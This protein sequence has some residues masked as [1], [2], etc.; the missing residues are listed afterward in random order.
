MNLLMSLLLLALGATVDV[1]LAPDQPLPY[2][3]IDDPLILEFRAEED[4]LIEAQI[5]VIAAHHPEERLEISLPPIPI[6]AGSSRW[7]AVPDLPAERG[8]YTVVTTTTLNGVSSQSHNEFSRIDRNT[9]R[10]MPML[11]AHNLVHGARAMPALQNAAVGGVRL[12]AGDPE[13]EQ[14]IH[15]AAMQGFDV[16]VHIDSQTLEDPEALVTQLVDRFCLDIARWDITFAEEI[17]ILERIVQTLRSTGC[18]API[19]LTVRDEAHL[20]DLLQQGVGL[21]VRDVVLLHDA[22]DPGS[23]R[24][25]QQTIQAAGYERWRIHV[26]GHGVPGAYVA[27]TEG[28]RSGAGQRLVQ[29]LL[30]NLAAG[31]TS[32]SIDARL[33]YDAGLGE[34]LVYLNALAQHLENARYVGPAIQTATINAPLFRRGNQWFIPL[35]IA[36]AARNIELPVGDVEQLTLTDVLNNPM[37]TPAVQANSGMISLGISNTP[38]FLQG[39]GGNILNVAARNLAQQHAAEVLAL[40]A[41]PSLESPLINAETREIL[42]RIAQRSGSEV[43]RSDFLLLLN[44]FPELEQRWHQGALPQNITVPALAGIAQLARALCVLERQRETPFLEPM[45]DI[46]NRTEEMQSL[47]LTGSTSTNARG[48]QRGDWLLR[49]VR[50]LMDEVEL[51]VQD[52]HKEEATAVANLAAWRARGLE[53]AAQAAP[54]DEAVRLAQAVAAEQPQALQTAEI[55][56]QR[57]SQEDP[58]A[59]P[60]S[61]DAA[62]AEEAD[63]ETEEAESP[64]RIVHEVVSGDTPGGIANRYGVSLADFRRWNN[65]ST[66]A[67]IRIGE[68]Y[69]IL[70]EEEEAE[71]EVEVEEVAEEA[72][73]APE[74]DTT[75]EPGQP[76]GTRKV[77][78]VVASGDNPSVIANRYNVTLDDFLEWNDLSRNVVMQVGQEFTVYV[79]E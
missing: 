52:G 76:A 12:E 79:A 61:T 34:S 71:E 29:Q 27:E 40:S 20:R 46:L 58:T 7:H 36:G 72:E 48:Q 26:L 2:I 30:D 25:L 4:G 8:F 44:C 77:I 57:L 5:E 13:I 66:N 15:S 63:S 39:E 9:R 14:R 59:A 70:L 49:E 68:E 6:R 56:D 47:Y 19:A 23:L 38:I 18:T 21:Y 35:W 31:V 50:R 67:V 1:H 75:L 51:L 74:T 33:V 64:G 3:Y 32:T 37:S 45:Q 42:Q 16:I 54:P 17:S 41:D 22:P 11:S 43:S 78:H 10:R 73:D 55:R 62:E 69:V 28:E 24:S 60:E 53:Y 65:L